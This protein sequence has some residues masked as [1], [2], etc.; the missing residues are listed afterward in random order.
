MDLCNLDVE[1]SKF[2]F[3]PQILENSGFLAPLHVWTNPYNVS[4]NQ[5]EL[6]SDNHSVSQWIAGTNLVD[7]REAIELPEPVVNCLE[8]LLKLEWHPRCNLETPCRWVPR[9]ATAA[10]NCH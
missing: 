3:T 9:A 2:V 8:S 10:A 6:I 7:G 4:C 1:A 5:F